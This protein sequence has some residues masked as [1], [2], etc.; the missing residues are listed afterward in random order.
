MTPTDQTESRLRRALELAVNLRAVASMIPAEHS[1]EIEAREKAWAKFDEDAK[2]ALA[3]PS[4]EEAGE[5]ALAGAWERGREAGEAIARRHWQRILGYSPN[6]PMDDLVAQGYG[7]GALNIEHAIRALRNPYRVPSV[8]GTDE[9]PNAILAGV[10]EDAGGTHHPKV[11]G[12]V[13]SLG[14][15]WSS[16]LSSRNAGDPM[17]VRKTAQM[18]ARRFADEIGILNRVDQLADDIEAALREAGGRVEHVELEESR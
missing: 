5:A 8:N 10:P 14:G 16:V 15:D 4:N 6:K 1:W 11:A 13:D 12:V 3:S 7:N 9:P 2:A 17:D 18:I